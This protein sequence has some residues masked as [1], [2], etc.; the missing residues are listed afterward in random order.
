MLNLEQLRYPI[1]KF[2]FPENVPEQ[3]ISSWINVLKEFPQQL[4]EQCKEL[5][6]AQLQLCYRDGGWTVAQIVHHLAD[7]HVNAYTRVKLTLT[8]NKPMIRPYFED[9]WAEL[10]DA[11]DTDI[12]LSINVIKAIHERLVLTLSQV[13]QR[14]FEKAYIYPETNM[15][16]NLAYLTGNYAWHGQHHLAHIRN[17][18]ACS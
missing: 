9:R 15:Q 5:N 6:K 2:V 17:A 8:E 16:Y 12:Q 1:G 3:Q 7:S 10:P 11:K 4:N 13:D 14:A 18:L